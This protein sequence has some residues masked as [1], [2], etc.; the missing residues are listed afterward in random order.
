MPARGPPRGSRKRWPPAFNQYLARYP[1]ESLP[2]T[3]DVLYWTKDTFGLKPVVSMYHATVYMPQGGRGLLVAIKTIYASHY[4]NAALEVMAAVPAPDTP[5]GPS[6]YLL[7]LYRTRID[8][9]TGMLSGVLMGKVKGGIEQGV[10]LNL[11]TA[12]DRVEGR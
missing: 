1:K 10:A 12:K 7:N 5:A 6:L 8:P 3:E 9:P 2:D 11:Q 4:F